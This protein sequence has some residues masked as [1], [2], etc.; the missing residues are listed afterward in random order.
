MDFNTFFSAEN[1]INLGT[2]LATIIGGLLVGFYTFSKKFAE[3]KTTNESK[4]IAKGDIKRQS[5]VDMKIIKRLEEAKECLNADRV[6]I[7]D[8][9]NGVHY[10][11][12]RSAIK[13]T[14]TYEACR[15][16][17]KSYQNHLSG[18]PISCL[19]NFISTLLNDGKFECKDIK[20]LENE[21]PA[22]YSF[23]KNMDI[24]SFYDVVFHNEDGDVVGFIAIQLCN[25]EFNINQEEIQRLVGYVEAELSILIE[26]QNRQED[27][28]KIK[29]KR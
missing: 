10:A 24:K 13:I 8:F 9:H 26:E 3:F 15:Y 14:C 16:G 18:L 12:G 1:M 17:I 6:Q 4:S 22:T 11:N 20:E 19:P 23:K 7:Y 27:I 5:E 29:E 2:N 28:S 21:Y 25:N